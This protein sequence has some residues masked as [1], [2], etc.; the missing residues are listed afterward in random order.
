[1][2]VICT[3]HQILLILYDQIKKN[4]MDRTCN[5]NAS[6]E[7]SQKEDLGVDGRIILKWVAR[8]RGRRVWTV[9][10]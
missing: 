10:A 2:I 1:M 8:T 4:E 6:D 5:T 9:F 7:E 3:A